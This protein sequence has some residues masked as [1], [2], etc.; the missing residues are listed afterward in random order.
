MQK[1]NSQN[2]LIKK[3]RQKPDQNKIKN[4]DTRDSK[5]YRPLFGTAVKYFC[6]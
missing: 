2:F 6:V 4:T 1:Q 3:R 5:K